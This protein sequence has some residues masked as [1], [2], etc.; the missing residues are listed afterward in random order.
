MAIAGRTTRRAAL[1]GW[2]GTPALLADAVLAI[3]YP[4]RDLGAART[5]RDSRRRA[6][7][8]RLPDRRWRGGSARADADPGRQRGSRN[9]ARAEESDQRARAR[10]RPHRAR[11]GDRPRADRRCAVG[12]ARRFWRSTAASTAATRSGTTCRSRRTSPRPGSVTALLYTDPLYLN[13]FYP[14]VSELLHAG[15][16]LLF[17]NDFLSPLLN[18]AWLGLAL[19][20]GWCIGRPYGSGRDLARRRGLGDGGEPAL[21]A[22]AGQRQQRRRRDRALPLRGR[23]AAEQ[24]LAGQRARRKP[25][26]RRSRCR[27]A[28]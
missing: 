17:G 13:W 7:G 16:I 23:A 6:A 21:L 9:G 28:P 8:C 18:M 20:A 4:G 5:V 25:Q 26:P 11:R 1:P 3:G 10:R 2:T 12:R 24:P 27:W 15:G 14:Q 22:P 19:F